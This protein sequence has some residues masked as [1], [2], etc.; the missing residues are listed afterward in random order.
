MV[1]QR[2]EERVDIYQTNPTAPDVP[3]YRRALAGFFAGA[4]WLWDDARY[5][6]C[7]W[8]DSRRPTDRLQKNR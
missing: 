2:L 5:Y 6:I 3:S 8:L 4:P 7:H 1:Y